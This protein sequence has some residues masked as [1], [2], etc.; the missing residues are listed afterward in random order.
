[1]DQLPDQPSDPRLGLAAE[2]AGEPAVAHGHQQFQKQQEEQLQ[3]Q[4]QVW[5]VQKLAV[6]QLLDVSLNGAVDGRTRTL[7][8][9]EIEVALLICSAAAQAP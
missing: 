9:S 1:M 6:A 2:L 7:R 8:V 4:Q 3:Q 5:Q